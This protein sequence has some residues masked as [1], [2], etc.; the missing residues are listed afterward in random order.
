MN[1]LLARFLKQNSE[2]LSAWKHRQKLV[3][4][5]ERIIEHTIAPGLE[6]ADTANRLQGYCCLDHYRFHQNNPM[7]LLAMPIK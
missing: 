3:Q 7:K 2:I 6:E 1:W 4:H 5:V